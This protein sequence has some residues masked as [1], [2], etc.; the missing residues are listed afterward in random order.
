MGDM[1]E[2]VTVSPK[3]QIVIPK[4]IRERRGIKPGDTM[5]LFDDGDG[6]RIVNTYSF[7]QL[8]G[9]LSDIPIVE[10]FQRDKSERSL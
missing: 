7:S 4:S 6:I 2:N 5:T 10:P 3:Y 9:L 8:R 1:V